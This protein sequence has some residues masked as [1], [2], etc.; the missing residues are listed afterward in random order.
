MFP[1]RFRFEFAGIC[2][3][4]KLLSSGMSRSKA[5]WDSFFQENTGNRYPDPAV[6]R[7]VARH[8]FKL[9]PR[10]RKSRSILDLGCGSG[11][12]TVFLAREGFKAHGLDF[13]RAAIGRLKLRLKSEKL[14]AELSVHDMISLPYEAGRFDAV[15]DATALQH[16]PKKK[17]PAIIREIRR[18]LKKK[19][20]FFSMI[21][22]SHRGLSDEKFPTSFLTRDEALKLVSE[23]SNVSLDYFE[24]SESSQKNKVRFWLID[25]E[26]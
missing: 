7:F 5:A 15:I 14:K 4:G 16:N 24:Y 12:H 3:V 10:A 8:F 18:V 11:N 2:G 23:F 1:G 21:I 26:K 20:R 9:A 13:S 22:A 17:I 19:G 6:I 25:A